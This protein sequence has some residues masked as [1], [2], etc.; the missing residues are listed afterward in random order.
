MFT[1]KIVVVVPGELPGRVLATRE[2]SHT[3]GRLILLFPGL[4]RFLEFFYSEKKRE[5]R[6]GVHACRIE[7][8]DTRQTDFIGRV[9]F[10]LEIIAHSRNDELRRSQISNAI[11][12]RND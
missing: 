8:R 1:V 12:A 7:E 11:R 2:M 3:Y 10:S 9:T 6:A 5:R 4:S